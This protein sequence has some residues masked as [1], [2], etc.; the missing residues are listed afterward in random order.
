MK[1]KKD[2]NTPSVVSLSVKSSLRTMS[3]LSCIFDEL[4]VL[5]LIF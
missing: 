2:E 1:V 3:S 4:P 5:V